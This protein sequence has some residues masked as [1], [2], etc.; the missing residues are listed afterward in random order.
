MANHVHQPVI[1]LGAWS[2]TFYGHLTWTG[3]WRRTPE[4]RGSGSGASSDWRFGGIYYQNNPFLSM[5]QMKFCLKTFETCSII[6]ECI[7]NVTGGGW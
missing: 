5:F 4:A 3:V 7:L 2:Y 1:S 6:I